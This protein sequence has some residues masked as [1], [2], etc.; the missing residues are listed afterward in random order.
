MKLTFI[1]FWLCLSVFIVI[2]SCNIKEKPKNGKLENRIEKVEE[3]ATLKENS[4]QKLNS[5][6]VRITHGSK[7]SILN[8]PIRVVIDQKYSTNKLGLD[9]K[10][11][12]DCKKLKMSVIYSERSF[13]RVW[14][15]QELKNGLNPLKD[16]KRNYHLQNRIGN[17]RKAHKIIPYD[18]DD[19]LEVGLS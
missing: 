10:N 14:I 19:E 3:D 4:Y 13:K 9:S 11:L 15:Q 17:N 7:E 16:F 5:L 12:K 2:I 1:I 6:L 18:K 8:K